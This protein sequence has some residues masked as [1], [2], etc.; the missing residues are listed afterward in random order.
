M[1]D[2]ILHA[3]DCLCMQCAE[4]WENVSDNLLNISA[5]S[6]RHCVECVKQ[7]DTVLENRL[8]GSFERVDKCIDC[9]LSKCSFKFE[10]RHISL[11]DINDLTYEEMQNELGKTLVK[12]IAK[13]YQSPKTLDE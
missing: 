8:E 9:L 1:S 11:E 2:N 5:R 10:K 4:K 13:L 3:G 7:H 6:V 12:I